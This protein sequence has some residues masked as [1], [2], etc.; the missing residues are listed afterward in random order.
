[1][2]CFR[3]AA[4]EHFSL[5]IQ[6]PQWYKEARAEKLTKLQQRAILRI[7]RSQMEEANSLEEE[8]EELDAS[9]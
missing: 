7:Q 2:Q 4:L 1:M 9:I 5:N 8:I 3:D 6:R